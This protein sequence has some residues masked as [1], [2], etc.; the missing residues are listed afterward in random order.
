MK[1]SII[2]TGHLGKIHCKLLS[3]NNLLTTNKQVE[4][5]GLYDANTERASVIAREYK[6]KNFATVE[7]TILA[8]DAVI[9]VVP[10]V[11]HFEIAKQC[12]ENGKHC[13]I[14][15]PVTST[16][17]EANELL[18]IAKQNPKLKVQVGHIER[19]NPAIKAAL[20]HTFPSRHCERSVAIH[21]TEKIDCHAEAARNDGGEKD[22]DIV[23]NSSN[24]Q[25]M[26]IEAH[27]L[28][29]FR[30]RATDVSVIHDLMIHDI[31]LVLWLVKSKIKSISANGLSVITNTVDI[32]NARICFENGAVAN[33]TASRI[34]ANPLRKIRFFQKFCYISVDLSKP[35]LD[36]F[37][38]AKEGENNPNAI[39]A[40]MLGAI[41]NLDEL[42]NANIF[43]NNI[44]IVFEK[45]KIIP[46]N[47]IAEEQNTFIT[48]ILDNTEPLVTLEQATA[49]LEVAEEIMKQV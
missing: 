9:I 28:S 36:I 32:A 43:K 47:A 20:N 49:A 46:T 10:T 44:N 17:A 35:D 39:T 26:F 6:V 5:I 25:P 4:F 12:L 27:R 42:D 1:I 23:N 11:N 21:K 34:S 41:D 22:S 15:K 24:F 38:L 7:E 29:Q 2:G 18:K 14:E 48:S 30:P 37:R 33:L 8:S 19:F 31:D 40:S 16:V 3:E 13:F 45:P